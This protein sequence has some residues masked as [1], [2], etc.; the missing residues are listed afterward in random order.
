MPSYSVVT[1]TEEALTTSVETVLQLR[2]ASTV[3]PRITG[4]GIAFDGVTAAAEPVRV[5]VLRQTTDGTGSAATEA[6]WDPD[7]PTA[8]CTA[9]H[10]FS[11]EPTAGDVLLE[12][13]VHPQGGSWDMQFPLGRE[14]VL[15]NA[16]TSRLGIDVLAPAAVNVTAYLCWEE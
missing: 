5:R 14:I 6:A 4:F 10:T 11:A 9:F 12:K 7:N 1:E 16:T 2:S 3:K 13:H 8:N 15:D